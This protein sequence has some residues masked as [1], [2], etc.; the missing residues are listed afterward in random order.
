VTV[1][2]NPVPYGRGEVYGGGHDGRYDNN[3]YGYGR[4]HRRDR[5]SYLASIPVHGRDRDVIPLGPQAGRY[6]RLMLVPQGRVWLRHA[7]VTFMNGQR[8]SVDLRDAYRRDGSVVI[9]LPGERRMVSTVE[10]YAAGRRWGGGAQ[11]ALYGERGFRGG[12]G[13]WWR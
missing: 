1:P 11:V 5:W 12:R 7:V 10:L 13:G 6:D 4:E 2:A 3:H 8:M 9:D